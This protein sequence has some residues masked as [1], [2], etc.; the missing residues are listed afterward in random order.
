MDWPLPITSLKYI[1]TSTLM[2]EMQVSKTT[3]FNPKLHTFYSTWTFKTMAGKEQYLRD[4]QI[5]LTAWRTT[6]ITHYL[7]FENNL[8]TASNS[9]KLQCAK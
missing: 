9:V 4:N 8:Y 5:L 2:T 7:N 1:T 6:A 3:V